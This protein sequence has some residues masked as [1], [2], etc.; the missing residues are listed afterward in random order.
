MNTDEIIFGI[1]MF[2][3]MLSL[4]LYVVFGQTTVKKLRK[5]IETK[6][7]LGIEF[8]SGWDILNVAQALALPRFI[9]KKLNQSS[10]SYLYAN[11]DLL[12]K[13]TNKF[14]RYL[15]FVLYWL[16]FSSILSILSLAVFFND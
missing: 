10:I 7:S 3:A 2:G 12:M 5:N 4:M 1:G 8:A 6:N 15:A 14:D 11:T 9:T 16:L 13:H